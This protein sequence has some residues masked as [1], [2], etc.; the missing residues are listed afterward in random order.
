MRMPPKHKQSAFLPPRRFSKEEIMRRNLNALLIGLSLCAALA[1][2]F[3]SSA[4]AQEQQ[5][6]KQQT[7]YKLVDLG[8]FGG[9]NSFIDC[10][11]VQPVLNNQGTIVGGAE[12]S[13]PNPN[14]NLSPTESFLCGSPD[15]FV[16]PAFKW[17]N[18]VLTNLGA[19]PGGYNSFASSISESDLATGTSETGQTDPLLGGPQCH[20]TLWANGQII[21]LGTLGGYQGVALESN[22][23][24]QV[25]GVATNSVP[26]SFAGLFANTVPAGFQPGT[27]QRAFLWER[28][29]ILDLGTLGGPDAAAALINDR[30]QIVGVSYTN[31]AVNASTGIPTQDPF[32]WEQGRILD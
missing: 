25:V 27:Q 20:P 14:F 15:P 32:L 11:G 21:D 2:P 30:G 9:P 28:G 23:Q 4:S 10:C 22:N 13:V 16:N 19:L 12:T 7:R 17:Q 1:L 29:V 3:V 8:T 24:G 26:D 6:K 31:S 5:L 18:G